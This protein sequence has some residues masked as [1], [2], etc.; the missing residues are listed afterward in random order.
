MMVEWDHRKAKRKNEPEIG[1]TVC[2]NPG[3]SNGLGVAIFGS[4]LALEILSP[5]LVGGL[6]LLILGAFPDA[7]LIFVSRLSGN[8]KISESGL[9]GNRVACRVDYNAPYNNMGTCVIVGKCDFRIQLPR[10]HKIPRDLA[11]PVLVLVPISG[12][13]TL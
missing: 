10:T 6:F 4:E 3:Y 5:G 1:K 9:C 12:R 8:T 2:G 7:M 11:Q 13:V